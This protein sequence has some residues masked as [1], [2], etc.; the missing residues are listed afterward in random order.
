MDF[1]VQMRGVTDKLAS[2]FAC[3]LQ[4]ET[5]KSHTDALSGSNCCKFLV[6]NL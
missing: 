1:V 6:Y 4:K 2:P 5:V 3:D